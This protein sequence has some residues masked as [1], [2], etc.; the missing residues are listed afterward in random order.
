MRTL[1][2]ISNS[3]CTVCCCSNFLNHE[4]HEGANIMFR[5]F[6][7]GGSGFVGRNLIAALRAHGDE[8]K[9]L[10]RSTAAAKAVENEGAEPVLGDLNDNDILRDA[11]AGCNVVFHS[12]AHVADWGR[13]E[14]F[15]VTNVT[16]TEC[17]LAAARAAGVGRFVHV[18]TEAV[19]VGGPPII[20]ADETWPLPEHPI[21]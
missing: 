21:G 12:A 5:A 11:M 15:Y 9:A 2:R 8:V 3:N 16:G 18:S 14:D 7:T 6:V 1:C 17:L 10:A 19:L 4:E 20:N 13:F